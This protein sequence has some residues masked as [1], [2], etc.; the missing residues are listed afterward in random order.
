MSTRL[1]TALLAVLIST[2]LSAPLFAADSLPSSLTLSGS[3]DDNGGRDAF[4]DIDLGLPAMHNLRLSLMAGQSRS[5]SNGQD[6]DTRDYLLG[7]SSDPLNDIS[8]GIEYEYWGD[9]GALITRTWRASLSFNE[10]DWSF[11]LQPQ[12]RDIRLFT[13][14]ACQQF[15]RCPSRFDTSS[16]GLAANLG[17]YR[18]PWSANLSYSVHDYEHQVSVLATDPRMWRI[19]SIPSQEL[20]TGFD[21]YRLGLAVYYSPDWGSLGLDEQYSESAVDGTKSYMT[22]LSLMTHLSDD[23]SLRLRGGALT[24]PDTSGGDSLF[25]GAS[26]TYSW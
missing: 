21:D 12:Y 19:F 16:V 4:V 20:A 18:G 1:F 25:A 5:H 11:A 13:S 23:W 9:E 24:V 2:T 10:A 3:A 14:P 7:L 15:P 6:Y 8:T 26:L 17:L 22:T